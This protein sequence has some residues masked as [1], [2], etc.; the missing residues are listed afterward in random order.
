[1]IFLKNIVKMILIKKISYLLFNNL[2]YSLLNFFIYN[3]YLYLLFNYHYYSHLMTI[4]YVNI[5][6]FY[7]KNQ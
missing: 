2:T 4:S 6:I 7:I 5:T 1:M 3:K